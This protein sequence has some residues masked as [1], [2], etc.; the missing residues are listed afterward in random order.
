M[1][2]LLQKNTVTATHEL[3]NAIGIGDLYS[4][5]NKNKLMYGIEN[6]TEMHTNC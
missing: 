3:G 4:V 1:V 6:R 2:E 5:V